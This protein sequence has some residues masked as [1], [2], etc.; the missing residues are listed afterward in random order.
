MQLVQLII[1]A[2]AAHDTIYQLGEVRAARATRVATL[3]GG[4]CCELAAELRCCR[5]AAGG[6]VVAAGAPKAQGQGAP[7]R[8]LT[9]CVALPGWLDPVQ[10][11]E[12]RQERIPAHL[13]QP[14]ARLRLGGR[15]RATAALAALVACCSSA[16][17]VCA[18]RSS[19]AMRCSVSCVSS[20]SRSRRLNWLPCHA[21]RV[22]RRTSWTSW[23]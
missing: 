15:A 16:F 18:R 11:P 12:R 14:G 23:R 8:F 22:T 5:R 2:E 20:A 7:L 13:R 21:R 3:A 17:A 10:G 4:V 1:P 6:L 9:L 19:A